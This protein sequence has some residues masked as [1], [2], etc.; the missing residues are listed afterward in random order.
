[1]F[2]PYI[3]IVLYLF[4]W[5]LGMTVLYDN[6]FPGYHFPMPRLLFKIDLKYCLVKRANT[7][8]KS[9]SPVAFE[10]KLNRKKQHRDKTSKLI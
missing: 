2:D 3:V 6:D 10:S 7:L 8:T 4:F 9:I 5:C 1:M